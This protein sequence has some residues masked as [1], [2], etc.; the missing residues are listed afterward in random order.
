MH[1]SQVKVGRIPKNKK[2]QSNSRFCGNLVVLL[3]GAYQIFVLF[4]F[5][6]Q[7]FKISVDE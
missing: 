7:T 1:L 3:I 5:G 6:C 4:G 2:L